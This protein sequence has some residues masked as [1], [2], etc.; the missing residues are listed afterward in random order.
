VDVV[1]S[2]TGTVYQSFQPFPG[3]TGIVNV[4]LG[5]VTG[6]G[7][8]D[9][10]VST[11]SA[12]SGNVMVFDDAAAIE[13]GVDFGNS[14]TWG[15]GIGSTLPGGESTPLLTTL[16]P[17]AGH[18]S[19]LNVAAGDVTGD[20][21][22]DVVV[23]TGAGVA[24]QVAVFEGSDFARV[25]KVFTPFGTGFTGG[26]SVATGDVTGNGIGDVIVGTATQKDKVRVFE[27]TGSKFVQT[28]GTLTPFGSGT[29]G[30]QIAGVETNSG[31][32]IVAATLSG[33]S[34]NV[35]V[36][37]GSG[38]VVAS[39]KVGKGLSG[40]ALGK[41]NP[42]ENGTDSV[43]FAGIPLGSPQFEY[44]DP[45]NGSVT[46]SLDGLPLVSGAISLAG[47]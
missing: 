12:F 37:D 44:L 19:G 16:T 21:I 46:S 45:L 15:N 4:T 3:Y 32:L 14:W 20:G 34:V 38:Q 40:F 8:P 30:V 11:R 13:P 23:A 43:L 47:S 10:V 36:S 9:L 28:G 24:G 5:D 33:G 26:L 27:F 39:Y 17:F 42:D 25:G 7:I 22:A 41:V 6:D 31:V 2:R 35:N 18:K 1:D 29:A